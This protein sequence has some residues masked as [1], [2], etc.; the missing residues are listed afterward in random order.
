MS[1]GS[2]TPASARPWWIPLAAIAAVVVVVAV[3][4]GLW[5]TATNNRLVALQENVHKSW[6]QVETV[7][8]R[9]F[10]LIPNLVAT[11]KG[12]AEHEKSTLEEV[13]R[14]RSQWGQA[15]TVEDKAQAA[16]ALDSAL[17]RLLVVSESYPELKASQNFRDLQVELSGTENRVSVE[18]ER[19]NEA[20]QSYN[21]SVRS[22]PTQLVAGW[23]GFSPDSAYFEASSKAQDAPKV[24][25]SAPA[26]EEKASE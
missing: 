7:L 16:S 3:V 19:Y 20:V 15:R 5:L 18:R 14:L 10:D 21:T 26:A 24:D 23:L 12:Y 2:T 13:T 17:S 8:Q 6:A 22:F 25:F 4:V 11:V 1:N 9:R